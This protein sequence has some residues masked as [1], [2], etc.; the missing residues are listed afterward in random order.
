VQRIVYPLFGPE[1]LDHHAIAAKIAAA[2]GIPVRF[3]PIDI[4]TFGA[5]LTSRGAPGPFVQHLTSVAQ[6]YQD[7]DFAGTNNLLEVL[8]SIKPFTVEENV[9]ASAAF[10]A[11]C[12]LSFEARQA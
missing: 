9:A 10:N 8:R 5:T 11:D 1:D 2:V 12:K 4:A 3:E 7:G 6:D